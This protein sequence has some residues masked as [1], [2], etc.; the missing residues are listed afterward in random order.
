MTQDTKDRKEKDA[1]MAL[2]VDGLWD[3][4]KER[5]NRLDDFKD[6]EFDR[7]GHIF[8]HELHVV[9]PDG[10]AIDVK[11]E[12]DRIVLEVPDRKDYDRKVWGR[13]R[14][15]FVEP[16]PD[17]L[18]KEIGR[19]L[20]LLLD[21]YTPLWNESEVQKTKAAA[22]KKVRHERA[23]ELVKILR[24][25][26][27]AVA[28]PDV[29]ETHEYW[30]GKLRAILADSDEEHRQLEVTMQVTQAG[31]RIEFGGP[32]SPAVAAAVAEALVPYLAPRIACERKGCKEKNL[33]EEHQRDQKRCQDHRKAERA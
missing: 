32:V 33:I 13:L 29:E 21:A 14:R 6:R 7:E 22:E 31:T 1:G 19:Q 16:R 12:K 26:G 15:S 5:I 10:R 4:I 23:L 3:E 17:L 27:G 24:S 18:G 8:S 11:R 9:H 30:D 20:K 25:K 28:E 2:G